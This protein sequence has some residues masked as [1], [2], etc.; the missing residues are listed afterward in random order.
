MWLC[1]RTRK[2]LS[3]YNDGELS[4]RSAHRVGRHIQECSSCRREFAEIQML[5]SLLG[6]DTAPSFPVGLSAR[7]VT[8]A[9]ARQRRKDALSAPD[10]GWR[11]FL[12]QPWLVRGATTAALVIGLAMGTWMGWT[13]QRISGLKPL[14]AATAHENTAGTIYAFDILG[15]QPRG[16]IEAATLILL[17]DGR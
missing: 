16:S 5:E 6:K 11:G 15:A 7:I 1:T 9:A 2:Y 10:R 4:D 13:S 8:E 12:F 14:M 3:A 17:A